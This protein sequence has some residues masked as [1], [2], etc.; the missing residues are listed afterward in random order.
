MAA[1]A[2]IA[3]LAA[4]DLEDPFAVAFDRKGTMYVAEMKPNRIRKGD[5][6]LGDGWKGPHHLLVA[7]NND[8]YVADTFNKKV[9][10]IDGK[11]GLVTTLAE[12]SVYCL[13]ADPKWKKL[14]IADLDGRRVQ[15]F[16]LKTGKMT[17]VAGNG[18][19][20]VPED[21]ADAVSQ[22][23]VDPRAVAVDAKSG[24]LYILE[25][26]GHALRAVDAKGKIRTV[27]GTGKKGFT[28]DGG[29]ALEATFNGP[30]HLDVAPNGD[31]LIVDTENHAIRRYL[32]K[33]GRIERFAGDLELKRPHGVIVGPKGVVYISDSEN[34]RVVTVAPN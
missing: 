22:P 11:T 2:L 28:G 9:K 4:A 5:A 34:N 21:G 10:K 20:G 6:V 16:D 31:V 12:I 26:G 24:T 15:A 3:L 13:A 17:V 33:T 14:F 27:A 19:K 8:I 25:R 32:P 29:P 23:L 7:P 1:L 30:K 18:E